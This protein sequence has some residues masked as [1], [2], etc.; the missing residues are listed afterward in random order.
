MTITTPSTD[1]FAAWQ[2]DADVDPTAA[3]DGGPAWFVRMTVVRL[4]DDEREEEHVEDLFGLVDGGGRFHHDVAD[5]ALED[6]GGTWRRTG[7]WTFDRRHQQWRAPVSR[8]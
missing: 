6:A 2:E 3:D 7:R 4:L 1:R 5:V 8:G